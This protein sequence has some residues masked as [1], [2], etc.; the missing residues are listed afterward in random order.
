MKR[1]EFWYEFASPYSYFSMMRIEAL[2][3]ASGID[4]HYQPFLLGPLFKEFGWDTSPFKIYAEKGENFFRDIEREAEFHDLPPIKILDEFPQPGLAAARV[5]L[6]GMEEGWGV[7][8]SKAIYQRQFQEGLQTK[9]KED[10][11]EVLKALNISDAEGVIEKA[12]SNENKNR[13]RE[14][15][16]QARQ[17]KIFGAPTFI[18]GNELFWGNDRLERAI[19]Y[20]K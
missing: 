8:F 13:L 14:I 10:V 4:V 18:V 16:E 15:T 5:A 19:S 3:A 9:G 7:E 12:N 6:I 2:A 20:C 1:L 11:L 17:K